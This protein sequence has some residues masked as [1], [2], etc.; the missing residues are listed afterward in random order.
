MSGNYFQFLNKT[1]AQRLAL[2]NLVK[3]R[4]SRYRVSSKAKYKTGICTRK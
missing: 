4:V 2:R 1:T 3:Y